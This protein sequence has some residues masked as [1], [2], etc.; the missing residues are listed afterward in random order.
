[1]S[2]D[3]RKKITKK[4]P[5]P[6]DTP[7]NVYSGDKREQ[8]NHTSEMS[9]DTISGLQTTTATLLFDSPMYSKTTLLN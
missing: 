7:I 9:R 1:M 5:E 3:N 4:N 6:K 8:T 2:K